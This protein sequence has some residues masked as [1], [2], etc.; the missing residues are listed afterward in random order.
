MSFQLIRAHIETKVND[1]FQALTPAVPVVFDN[2]QETPPNA[3]YAI[4]L[5]SYSSVTE[6]VLCPNGEG[7][8]NLRGNIQLSI[9]SQRGRG[10]NALEIYG[11][12][13]IRVL[14]EMYDRDNIVRVKC[15]QIL[16]PVPVLSGAEPYALVTLSCPFTAKLTGDSPPDNVKM[17]TDEVELVTDPF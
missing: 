6:T 11:S 16:G 17:Y 1:A 13:G 5:V 9:Y 10:M 15:G 4:C 3:P 12:T 2:V 8:E 7:I 14:N